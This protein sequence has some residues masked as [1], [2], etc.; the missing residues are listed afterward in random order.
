META[1]EGGAWGIALLAAYRV[2]A[3]SGQS[4]SDYLESE[5]FASAHPVE[6]KPRPEDVEGFNVYLENYRRGLCIEEAAVKCKG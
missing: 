2:C 6:V 4:L 1:G 5:I 3:G